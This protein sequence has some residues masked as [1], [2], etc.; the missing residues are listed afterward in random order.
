MEW[1]KSSFC[2][3]DSP[4]CVEVKRFTHGG[5]LDG[6]MLRDT[7]GSVVIYDEDEWQTFIAGVKAG[8][9]DA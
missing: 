2:K 5:V 7:N 1:I 4:M 6:A 8:E 9:F 3:A